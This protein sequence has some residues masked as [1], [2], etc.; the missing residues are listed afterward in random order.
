M[1]PPVGSWGKSHT[2]DLQQGSHKF[3]LSGGRNR[4][5]ARGG[6]LLQLNVQVELRPAAQR[7]GTFRCVSERLPAGGA[8]GRSPHERLADS[9]RQDSASIPLSHPANLTAVL[10]SGY[11]SFT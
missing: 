2:Q 6:R 9:R 5:R 10:L 3:L 7:A 4:S 11:Q 1:S 8:G